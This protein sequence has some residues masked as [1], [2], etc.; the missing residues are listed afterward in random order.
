M[1]L[2]LCCHIGLAAIMCAA[3][4]GGS[5]VPTPASMA[6]DPAP[7]VTVVTVVVTAT[8]TI[9]PAPTATPVPTTAE[10]ILAGLQAAGLPIT[11]TVSFTAE[12]DPNHLLGR[13][14]GYV[15]KVSFRDAR[16]PIGVTDRP[17]SVTDGGTIEVYPAPAGAKARFD[18]TQGLGAATP[19]LIEYGFLKGRVLLRLTDILTPT[20]ADEYRAAL[21]SIEVR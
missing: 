9:T 15:S 7:H 6:D 17:I 14:N 12:T 19:L 18:Y 20:Q 8:P 3:C 10:A 2:S 1:K 11:E 16:V 13:P 4:S 21:E 5:S